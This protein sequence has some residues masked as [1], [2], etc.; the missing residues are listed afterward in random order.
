MKKIAKSILLPLV[1]LFFLTCDTKSPL[2]ADIKEEIKLKPN[3][4]LINISWQDQILWVLTVD[5]TTNIRYFRANPKR[6]TWK[7]EVIIK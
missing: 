2:Q 4:K 6:T 5:T 7:G 3:E 1:G